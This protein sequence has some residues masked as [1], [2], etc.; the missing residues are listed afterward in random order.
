MNV[1]VTRVV[2]PIRDLS[3]VSRVA[4][5]AKGFHSFQLSKRNLFIEKFQ[6]KP[7]P[8]KI[9]ARSGPFRELVDPC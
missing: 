9:I 3:Q 8:K 5:A 4:N 1:I 6:S 2:T 7:R